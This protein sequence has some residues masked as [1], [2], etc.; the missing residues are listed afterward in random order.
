VILGNRLLGEGTP[1]GD[2]ILTPGAHRWA[3]H[4]APRFN[5]HWTKKTWYA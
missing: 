1:P 2:S 5:P 4:A 3:W